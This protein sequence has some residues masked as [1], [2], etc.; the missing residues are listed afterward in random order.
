MISEAWIS[1][2]GDWRV[3]PRWMISKYRNSC[4]NDDIVNH[5]EFYMVNFVN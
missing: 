4:Q 5:Y 1:G 3:G 2:Y